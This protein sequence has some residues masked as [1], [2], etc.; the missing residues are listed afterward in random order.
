MYTDTK[1]L[2]DQTNN[3]DIGQI[4]PCDLP[5]VKCPSQKSKSYLSAFLAY[6]RRPDRQHVNP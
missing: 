6:H 5:D 4:K 1:D 3:T 2:G